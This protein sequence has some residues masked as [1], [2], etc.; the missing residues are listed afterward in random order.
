MVHPLYPFLCA[1]TFQRQAT[2]PD[3][4][5]FLATDKTFAAL[6][7][8][9]VA[10]GCQYNDGGSYEAGVGE[11]WSYFERSLS[12]FQDLIFFRGSLTAVQV[13]CPKYEVVFQTLTM[14]S[15]KGSH[16]YGIV[17]YHL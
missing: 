3:L 11:A 8:A 16:G 12:Y 14:Y 4:L 6:F 15:M 10:I 9:V 13:Y 5:H 2:S 7:Y 17:I 1:T